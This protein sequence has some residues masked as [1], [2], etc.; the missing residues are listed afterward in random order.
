MCS[1]GN[2]DGCIGFYEGCLCVCHHM[3]REC[4]AEIDRL[5][6]ENRQL[7]QRSSP[8]DFCECPET[9]CYAHVRTNWEIMKKLEDENAALKAALSEKKIN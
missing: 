5:R 7:R 3:A 4:R 2:E 8:A 6:V 9:W 1:C